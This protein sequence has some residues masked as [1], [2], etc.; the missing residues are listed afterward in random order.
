[1]DA[2]LSSG[3]RLQVIVQAQPFEQALTHIFRQVGF[4]DRGM[5]QLDGPLGGVQYDT[6]VIAAFEMLLKLLAKTRGKVA[7][8]IGRQGSQ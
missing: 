2:I 3:C 7:I 1:M 4:F 6:A 5:D 8:D